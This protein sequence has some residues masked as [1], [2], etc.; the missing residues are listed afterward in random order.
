MAKKAMKVELL[1]NNRFM[2]LLT[3][4]PMHQHQVDHVQ[5]MLLMLLV[6]LLIKLDKRIQMTTSTTLKATN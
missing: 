3:K 2:I 1:K 5:K 4:L 6:V